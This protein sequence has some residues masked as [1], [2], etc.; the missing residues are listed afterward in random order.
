M[1]AALHVHVDGV[2]FQ[3]PIPA[4]WLATVVIFRQDFQ[5]IKGEAMADEM[6]APRS[7]GRPSVA[8][9]RREQIFDAVEDCLAEYGLG[10]ATLERIADQAG[11]PRSAL[12]HFVGNRDE[13]IDEAINR[14]V[15]R[16]ISTMSSSLEDVA[17][18]DRLSGFVDLTLTGSTWKKR[19]LIV[20]DEVVA[21][22]HH[23]DDARRH[24]R[25]SYERLESVVDGYVAD[26]YPDALPEERR[27]AAAG[28][29]LLLRE[30]DRVRTLGASDTPM[31]LRRRVRATAQL[32]ID[33]V[34]TAQANAS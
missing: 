34:G 10:G 4:S 22:A 3:V 21:Y 13:V 32:I 33:S 28:L 15:D 6:P 11:I 1:L 16:F 20:M 12:A 8:P 30:Y 29:I 14:S 2:N 24:L 17:P 18:A 31:N 27:T 23:S 9:E 26:R 19:A 25:E 7:V 5:S